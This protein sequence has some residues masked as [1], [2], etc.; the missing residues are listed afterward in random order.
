MLF[1]KSFKNNGLLDTDKNI[2]VIRGKE[3]NIPPNL[4]ISP[5]DTLSMRGE[6]FAVLNSDPVFFGEFA[7]RTAQ[8]I[9]PWDAA[10]IIHYLNI[11]PGDNV[12]ESGAGSGAL[13]ASIL[14][15]V[16]SE[17]KLTTVEIERKNIDNAKRN[18]SLIRDTKNWELQEGNIEEFPSREKYDAIVLDIPEPWNVVGRLSKNLKNGKKIC[19]Y[20]PTYNQMEKNVSALKKGGYLVLESMELLKR[21]MLVREY[22][23]RPDNDVIGHTA[24]L[25]FAVKMSGRTTKV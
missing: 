14:E 1:L 17:G 7:N 6:D 20:S 4:V 16:G 23:T 15:A 12:L 13:S 9:Q 25:T 3:Y 18:V 22:A 2:A 10:A 5:G 8:I 11:S 24:F 19:C 21:G